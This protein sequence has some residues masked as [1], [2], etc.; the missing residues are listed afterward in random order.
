ML[1]PYRVLDLTDDRGELAS[2]M[3]GDLGA[4]V[5][6]VE[7]PEGSS[8]RRLPPFLD[9]AP[10][11]ERSLHYFAFNR[12]K[13]G[14]TLD[15]SE[16]AGKAELIRLAAG[17]DFIFESA[18]PGAMAA[19]GL[20]S[21][22]LSRVNP[23]LVYVAITP[24]GQDGPYARFAASDLTLSAMGGQA[25]LQG[26]PERA[27]VRITVPQ[28]WL[29]A[30]SEAAVAALIAHARMLRTGEAQFVDVSAQAAMVWS[31][32]QGMVAHAIQGHD[33][34]RA[35]SLLQLGHMS[36]PVVYEC[37]DGHVLAGG[38]NVLMTLVPWFAE[39]GIVPAEWIDG[40]DWSRSYIIRLLQGQPVKYSWEDV[41]DASRRY[42]AR[43]TKDELMERG[44]REGATIAPANTVADLSQFR[45]LEEREY[46]LE[47]PLTNGTKARMPGFP[48][49]SSE[50]PMTVRRWAPRVGEHGEDLLGAAAATAR[51]PVVHAPAKDSADGKSLPFAGLKV[52]DFTWIAAGPTATKYL[53]DHGATVVRVET[54]NPP[55][56]LR[57]S[58]PYKDGV[59][60]AN[61]S[62]FFGDYN[63]SK[64]GISL[65]LK[66]PAGRDVARRLIEWADVCVNSFTPGTMDDLGIGY[67]YARQANPSIIFA[68][69]CLMGQTG[70][71]AA[72]AGYG[73]HAAA[74]A[75]FFEVTGWPDLPPDGPWTAY[76]DVVSPRFFATTIMAALDRRRRTGGGEFIDLSQLESSLTFLAPQ[77]IDYQLS[78][79]VAT[80]A[81]NRS[82]TAAPHAVY[83]C[84]GD[85]QWCAI[86]VETEEQWQS[87]RQALGD[88]EWSR[89]PRFDNAAGRLA[90]QEE[91]DAHLS[92]WTRE[93]LPYDVMRL[94]QEAAVPAGV[95]QR[96]SDLLKDP[97]LAHRA[98]HHYMEHPEMGNIPYTGHEFRIR[99]YN[100]GP[101]FPAPCL[102]QHNEH[103]MREILGMTDEEMAEVVAAGAVV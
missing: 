92:E 34:N 89:D 68:S 27:P 55:D 87:L 52:A 96:S 1:S 57:A 72:F 49:R 64:F 39:D 30:A 85:D 98:F 25:A 20:G 78:G 102:G 18:A 73:Y 80:R 9:G 60:G 66:N 58:G 37:A 8:S 56:T 42:F 54:V 103:V 29:H 21:D 67:E 69:S 99:G 3:L 43:H 83:P 74:I 65:D 45:Q 22:D 13:R 4:D 51:P 46:W 36:L 70:P 90:G 2:M 50:A 47:A 75:G 16:D 91:I 6:K 101:R 28:V 77:L 40:E 94:L 35:G 53:A 100:S 76:T 61:R 59:P 71:A 38:G 19:A 41:L 93:R 15:L 24:Y 82:E 84:A 97:Q 63:T 7:P 11:A 14:I 44:I 10:E 31:M 5:I 32:M 81:G 12:N 86:V 17:A 62:Q 23:Q 26:V 88:P 33:F 79:R 95:A 48:A